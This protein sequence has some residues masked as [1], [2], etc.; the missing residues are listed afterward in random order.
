[1]KKYLL[2]ICCLV[3]INGTAQ[4][5]TYQQKLFYSCK[6][7]GFVKYFHSGVSTCQVNWDS[8]LVSRLPHIK[9]AVTN[10]DFN[11]QLDTLLILAGPM[12]IATTALPDTIQPELKRNRNFSWIND[13]F[14]RTD[15]KV[16]LDT[17]KNNFRPHTSC[18]V[19]DKIAP[20]DP[21]LRLPYD[22]LMYPL[23][24]YTFFPNEQTRLKVAFKYWNILSYFNPN[25]YTMDK[26]CD[27]ILYNRILLFAN[28]ATGRDF[29]YAVERM[30]ADL[31]DAH[32]EDYTWT[33]VTGAPSYY[34]HPA[35]RITHVQNKYIVVKS[36]IAAIKRGDEIV[37]INGVAPTVMEDSLRPYVSAG[38]SAV[39]YRFMST[40]ILNGNN[41]TPVNIGYKDSLGNTF[42]INTIRNSSLF[43]SFYQNY[44]PNDTLGTIKWKKFG[45]NIGYVNMGRIY[46]ADVATMY[47]NLMNS[48]AIIF[49]L[50]NYPNEAAWPIANAMYASKKI[51]SKGMIPDVTYPGTYFWLNDSLGINGNSTPY[52]GKVIILINEDS[53]SQSEYSSMIFEAMPDVVKVGSQTAGTDGNISY[54][55]VSKDLRTT[56]TT[57]GIFYP[58]GDSTQRIGIVPD[59]V[60]YQTQLGIRHHRDEVLEKA[61]QVANCNIPTSADQLTFNNAEISIYPNPAKSIITITATTIGNAKINYEIVDVLGKVLIE[62]T[63]TG[64]DKFSVNINDLNSGVY[65]LRLQVNNS[66]VVKKFVKE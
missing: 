51:F 13:P 44:Y 50:R 45:C 32:A 29:H 33:T 36:T 9:N 60:V 1:M 62:N 28:A 43:S 54:F 57:L 65:F 6:V 46:P 52:M 61:L 58:N 47:S 4:N 41:N 64:F 40:Y 18:W 16:K 39:F 37:S 11:D 63:H 24:A 27:S 53:Q 15:I 23:N 56:I 48:P 26:P 30:S 49:D 38:N 22:S 12:A 8:V 25:N 5:P 7:W 10:N 66:T 42:N 31:N 34:Y 2:I 14:I 59:S 20:S 17:I 19:K 3:V 55:F 35:I 21:W